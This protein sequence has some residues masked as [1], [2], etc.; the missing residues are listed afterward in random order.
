M[1]KTI[2]HI[3]LGLTS[4][5]AFSASAAV[6]DPAFGYLGQIKTR[7][8]LE[9]QNAGLTSPFGI[10]GETTDRGFSTFSNWKSYLGPL[11]AQKIRVQSGWHFIEKTITTPATYDFTTLDEI[12]DGARLQG[13]APWVFLGYGNEQ[14]GCT[15]CGTKGLGAALP[16]L[17]GKQRFL[18]F[19]T[20]TVSRYK[21]K[22]FDW[23]IWNEPDGH[24]NIDEYKVFIVD[25]A[26]AIKAI[27]PNAK[28]SIGSFTAGT[29]GAPGTAGYEFAKTAVEY[30]AAN[31]GPTVASSDVS[32][33]YH[34][35]WNPVDYES[36]TSEAT[37]FNVMKALAEN[38]GFKLRQGE[39]GAPSAPCLYFNGCELAWNETSQAKFNL[40]RMVTDFAKGMESNIFTITD[41]HYDSGKNPKGLLETGT[42]NA[43]ID[44]PYINGDQTVKRKKIAYGAFQ[45]VTAVFDNRL[46][47]IAAPNCT[48]PYGYNI[49]AFTRNDGGVIRNMLAVWKKISSLPNTETPTPIT[50][51]C[52]GFHFPRLA[53]GSLLPRYADLL[54]GRVYSTTTAVIT[55]NNAATNAVTIK[56]VPVGD[57][58]V[59]IADQG[60]VLY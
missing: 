2:H 47:L 49:K 14:S 15:N 55:G 27:Q 24:V 50:V 23:E 34:P 26:K 31:K 57:Y 20:A 25:V 51:T 56:N 43:S 10:G 4:I 16:S 5:A 37:K 41:L 39:A 19:V 52:T 35:Y 8:T 29:N 42:F 53:V 45:N 28:L 7:T 3:V 48:V 17:A 58:P 21:T 1:K 11:G 46:A 12:I 6:T 22:V 38:N 60:I 44:T 33:S 30:F 59:L 40:L 36:Y 54:D 9:I 13:V 18:N 32:V